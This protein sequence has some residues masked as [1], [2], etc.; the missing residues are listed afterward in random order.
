MASKLE[1]QR[2][3]VHTRVSGV[4]LLMGFCGSRQKIV[5]HLGLEMRGVMRGIEI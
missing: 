5:R 3:E 1:R 4:V 2:A